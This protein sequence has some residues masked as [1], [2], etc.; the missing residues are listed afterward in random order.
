MDM[1]ERAYLWQILHLKPLD[2][3]FTME[4]C[5]PSLLDAHAQGRSKA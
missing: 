4:Q 5:M 2:A 3:A 1:K